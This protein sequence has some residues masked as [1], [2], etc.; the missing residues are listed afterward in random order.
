MSNHSL[1]T[2]RVAKAWI[3]N[4]WPKP[5]HSMWFFAAL[6]YLA[7]VLSTFIYDNNTWHGKH[8]TSSLRYFI[9]D[10]NGQLCDDAR[11]DLAPN[12]TYWPVAVSAT[13][14][15]GFFTRT[16]TVEMSS[17]DWHTAT[18]HM[19][20]ASDLTDVQRKEITI[21]SR[22]F[23]H[24]ITNDLERDDIAVFTP[25]IQSATLDQP[26]T[27]TIAPLQKIV[28]GAIR[29]ALIP[30][31]IFVLIVAAIR[32]STRNRYKA[33]YGRTALGLCPSCGYEINQ[34]TSHTCPECGTNYADVSETL[35]QQFKAKS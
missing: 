13:L 9:I 12:F 17:T 30:F 3:C 31:S 21:R 14:E 23:L 2:R 15:D 24:E 28:A 10:S 27:H 22:A 4:P 5:L 11:H 16:A 33:M 34:I 6:G 32:L 35:R 7:F 29:L 26:T 8:T 1:S 19:P 20:L 25:L 18:S